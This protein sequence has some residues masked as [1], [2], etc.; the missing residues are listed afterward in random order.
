[1]WSVGKVTSDRKVRQ[2][3]YLFF[4][5][6]TDVTF[7]LV[8]LVIHSPRSLFFFSFIFIYVRRFMSLDTRL[9]LRKGTSRY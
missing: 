1:M 2:P 6:D 8:I 7:I 3:N 4:S 9:P 5:L